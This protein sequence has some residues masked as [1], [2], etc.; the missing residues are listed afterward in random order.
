VSDLGWRE[1]SGW[2]GLADIV[3]SAK[4]A[5]FH[6]SSPFMNSDNLNPYAIPATQA[7]ADTSGVVPLGVS[8]ELTATRPWV[9]VIS[10]VMWIY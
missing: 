9:R 6:S 4:A 2:Q 8:K 1:A 5:A 10:T 3:G 7:G